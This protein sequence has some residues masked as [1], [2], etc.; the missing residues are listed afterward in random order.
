MVRKSWIPSVEHDSLESLPQKGSTQMSRPSFW[1]L[2]RVVYRRVTI[3]KRFTLTGSR[4]GECRTINSGS[5][6]YGEQVLCG[7][8]VPLTGDGVGSG[9]GDLC[10]LSKPVTFNIAVKDTWRGYLQPN[11]KVLRM[12]FFVGKKDDSH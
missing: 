7:H 2:L 5:T 8:E 10:I 1:V 11:K 4:E 12:T 3:Y 9:G 6:Y